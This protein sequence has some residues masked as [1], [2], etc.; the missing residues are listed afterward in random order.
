MEGILSGILKHRRL[1]SNHLTRLS[2]YVEVMQLGV[3]HPPPI[4]CNL[5]GGEHFN[6]SYHLY[7]M[8]NYRWDQELHPYN[9]Y[10][11]KILS[12]LENA[13][14]QFMETSEANF[15]VNPNTVQNL[16]I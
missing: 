8:V 9:Q 13:L 16:E 5:C 3:I 11:E 6:D 2:E 12:N 10:K 14:M 7:S 15:K 4:N 1:L